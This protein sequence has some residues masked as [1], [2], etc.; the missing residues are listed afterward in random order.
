MGF[1]ENPEN[2]NR[3]GRPKKG[4][5]LT[6]ILEKHL[7]KRKKIGEYTKENKEWVIKAL[8]ELAIEHKVICPY[9][10]KTFIHGGDLAA[11]KYIF[12][13]TDGK[14]TESIIA[15]HEVDYYIVPPKTPA[16]SKRQ[17]KKK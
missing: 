14:P 16:D 5:T 8:I 10:Q 3:K 4:T 9:C 7:S 6:D 1:R 2:I 17:S 11:L 13:R 15:E 12:D